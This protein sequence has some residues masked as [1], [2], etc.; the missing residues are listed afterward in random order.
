MA[1]RCVGLAFG[2]PLLYFTAR[3]YVDRTLGRRLALLFCMGGTQGLVGWWMVR[4]GLQ[5]DK[6]ESMQLDDEVSLCGGVCGCGWWG[7]GGRDCACVFVVVSIYRCG[8]T[9]A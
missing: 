7:G 8:C 3:G 5:K 1:G 2:V 9:Y 4:S 6:L